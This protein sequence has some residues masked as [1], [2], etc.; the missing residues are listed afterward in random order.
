MALWAASARGLLRPSVSSYAAAA[1]AVGFTTVSDKLVRFQAI[2]EEGTRVEVGSL[3][4]RPLS[5]AL[6]ASGLRTDRFFQSLRTSWDA[7]VVVTSEWADRLPH[8]TLEEEAKLVEM[9]EKEDITPKYARARAR[10]G[11]GRS[12]RRPA[13]RAR[14]ADAPTRR[15]LRT[16]A[17]L[18]SSR[19]ASFISVTDDLHGMT[20]ALMPVRS[21]RTL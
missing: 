12:V 8:K 19:I 10:T 15:P 2:N 6:A 21:W 16:R 7:H 20:V 5:A 1:A 3:P 14:A 11:R 4:G 17:A 18:P 13:F 9:A